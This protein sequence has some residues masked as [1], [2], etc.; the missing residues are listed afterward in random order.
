MKIANR[1]FLISGGS[2]GLGLATAVL[3]LSQDANVSILDLNPPPPSSHPAVSDSSRTHFTR[4]DVSSTPS[5]ASA[6][7][8]TIQWITSTHKPLGGVV[9]CAGIGY[10]EKALPRQADNVSPEEVKMMDITKFD[11]VLAINLR[12]TVDL[13][14][15]T[16]PHLSL[17]EPEEPDD[18]RGVII[19]VSSVAA[20]EGQVGQ[21]AYAASKGAVRSLVLPLAREVGQSAGVRVVGVA[22]G[23]FE[24]SMTTK[25][26]KPSGQP[27]ASSSGSDEEPKKQGH[28][29]KGGD[30]GSRASFNREMVNYP[31]RMGRGDEFARL[32][33]EI[34]ENPM[35]NG[36]VIR[37]DGGVRMPSRL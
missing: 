25:P 37:L 15:Q 6:I 10:A 19:V 23:I 17:N 29:A 16:L 22:P 1:T 8:S 36:E 24:T 35:L 31:L 3:L 14:R 13:I 27:K 18:E 2:S 7:S 21:L 28:K 20:F 12:G 26:K 33:K 32:A 34:I 4:T 9:C 11:R 5:I 30:T